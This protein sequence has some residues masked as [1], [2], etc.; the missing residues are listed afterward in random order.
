MK[1]LLLL[2][3]ILFVAGC[4]LEEVEDIRDLTK[5][6]QIALLNQISEPRELGYM[7]NYEFDSLPMSKDSAIVFQTIPF[8]LNAVGDSPTGD[9]TY[10]IG[11]YE[12]DT[13]VPNPEI[14]RFG[15]DFA[16]NNE[17]LNL[18]NA[19]SAIVTE[20]HEG[21]YMV[22]I[23]MDSDTLFGGFLDRNFMF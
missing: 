4:Q 3:G 21:K 20:H 16:D 7:I 8:T 14:F 15:Y 6:E 2:I 17:K 1:N 19:S 22:E 5:E 9:F 12:C 18:K 13:G 10:R 11:V 23:L